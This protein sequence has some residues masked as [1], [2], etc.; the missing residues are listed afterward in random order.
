MVNLI[1]KLQKMETVDHC[2]RE[3]ANTKWRFDKPSNVTDFA[4]LLE[5]IP[6]GCKDTVLHETLSKYHNVNC[7]ISRE[8]RDNPTMTTSVCFEHFFYI[9]M[10]TISWKSRLEKFSILV[11]FNARK[12]IPQNFKLFDIPKVEEM[13]QLS[14]F[15]LEIDSVDGELFGEFACQSIQKF[16]KSV[17][18]LCYNNYICY[19]NNINTLF[20][21]FRCNTCETFLSKTSNLKRL[22]VTCS[23]RVKRFYPN[24]VNEQRGT[25]FEK[26]IL[27]QNPV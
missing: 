17:K 22:L 19:I 18:L 23:E 27:N 8:I 13:L 15:P 20:K 21:A 1:E 9:W 7:L 14:I 26:T 11:A 4:A 25:I 3:T 6:M 10:E 2:T 12:V 16:D 24:N 5:D